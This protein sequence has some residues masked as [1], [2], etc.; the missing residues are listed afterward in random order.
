LSVRA[1]KKNSVIKTSTQLLCLGGIKG[2]VITGPKLAFS[3]PQFYHNAVLKIQEV[4]H[5]IAVNADGSF[6]S[7]KLPPFASYSLIVTN[8]LDPLFIDTIPV[9]VK[10]GDGRQLEMRY[11]DS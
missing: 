5:V 2:K 4:N 1:L 6:E 7:K 9:M 11:N 10:A 8:R 3:S